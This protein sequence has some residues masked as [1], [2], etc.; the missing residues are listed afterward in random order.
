MP[1]KRFLDWEA[2]R[3]RGPDCKPVE[4]GEGPDKAGEGVW[5]VLGGG[6]ASVVDSSLREELA[7]KAYKTQTHQ[8]D[9]LWQNGFRR[10]NVNGLDSV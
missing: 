6:T 8:H 9:S 3:S 10:G 4:D 5:V 2:R 1:D 7:G